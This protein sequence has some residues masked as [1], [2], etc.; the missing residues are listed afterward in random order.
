M[1]NVNVFHIVVCT[2]DHELPNEHGIALRSI[3]SIY[4]F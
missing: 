1:I 4:D 2:F 3:Y